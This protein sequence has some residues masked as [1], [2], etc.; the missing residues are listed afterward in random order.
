MAKITSNRG[1]SG[2]RDGCG[3]EESEKAPGKVELG[4]ALSSSLLWNQVKFESWIYQ[5]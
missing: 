5:D 3:S 4:L 1:V 2:K